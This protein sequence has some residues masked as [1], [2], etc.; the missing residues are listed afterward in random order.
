MRARFLIENSTF[1]PEVLHVLFEAFDA[2]W[3]EIASH[4][5]GDD[6]LLEEARTRLAHAVLIVAYDDSDEVERVKNDALQIMAL[7]YREPLAA[8]GR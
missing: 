4:F 3:S 8:S 6:Q 1:S 7:G 5:N 2:A